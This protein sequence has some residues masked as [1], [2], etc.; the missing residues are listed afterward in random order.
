[1]KTIEL[2][3]GYVAKAEGVFPCK[4]FSI[5]TAPK[6]ETTYYVL[7]DDKS[8]TF[9]IPSRWYDQVFD[10]PV[11]AESRHKELRESAIETNLDSVKRH[12]ERLRKLGYE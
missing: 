6:D 4:Y 5:K 3:D 7:D 11:D 12:E 1:M 2:K 10:N 8:Q 9:E